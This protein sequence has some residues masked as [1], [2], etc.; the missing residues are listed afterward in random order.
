M[1]I[2]RVFV[3]VAI[4]A[5]ATAVGSVPEATAAG[6]SID[7]LFILQYVAGLL[8]SLPNAPSADVN[9]RDG[10]NAIDAALILQLE[11]GLIDSLPP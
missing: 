3:L 2:R 10:V 7:A 6:N 9:G 5:L 8:P 1:R 11:A 4:S